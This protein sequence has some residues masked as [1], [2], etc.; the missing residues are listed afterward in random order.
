MR[1]ATNVPGTGPAGRRPRAA[2]GADLRGVLAVRGFRRLVTVRLVSQVCDGFFQAGLAGSVLFNPER[3]TG[4]TAIALGFAVLLLPYSFVG[5]FVGVL[6]DRWSRRSVLFGANLLR[7]GLVV[8][9]AALIW[10]GRNESPPFLLLAL[11]IIAVNRFFLAGLSASLPHVVRPDRLVTA[12]AVASTAGT[13]CYT[14]GLG[15]AALAV[16]KLVGASYRGY[17]AVAAF[18]ALGYLIS[19]LTARF[20]FTRDALGPGPGERAPGT[21]AAA[22]LDVAR[23][24]VAGVRHLLDRPSAA[25]LVAIQSGFRA[26]YGLLSLLALLLYSHHPVGGSVSGALTGLGL[27]VAAG[28]TGALLSAFLTP[29]M[30]RRI[31]GWRWVALLLAATGVCVGVLG[32]S[33]RPLPL[34]ATVFVLNVTLQG[35]KIV[36]DA[37]LQYECA[38]DFR[39]RVFS[40]N[41]T[42]YNVLYVVGL[43]VGA[44][45]LPPDGRSVPAVLVAAAGYLLLAVWYAVV[46][47]RRAA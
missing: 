37:S 34:A 14:L 47:R 17:A 36:V 24:M 16:N 39:G 28:G 44:A 13:V 40:V 20:S 19:S 46:S 33:F 43:F 2:T 45:M 6:L 22:A 27:L 25:Y 21:V 32:P 9:A 26:L 29:V 12:N 15:L 35:V 3:Q 5:P 1:P 7:A 23:G 11:V 31:G 10:A 30:T 18:A 42:T 8:P 38:D 4:A 41:D